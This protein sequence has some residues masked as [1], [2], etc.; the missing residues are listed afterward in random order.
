MTGFREQRTRPNYPD[1]LDMKCTIGKTGYSS[2]SGRPQFAFPSKVTFSG[3][4]EQRK[5]VKFNN[6]CYF[7]LVLYKAFFKKHLKLLLASILDAVDCGYHL[8]ASNVF[9]VKDKNIATVF[10]KG[11]SKRFHGLDESFYLCL[12]LSLYTFH[13]LMMINIWTLTLVCLNGIL[14]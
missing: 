11:I 7:F 5:L 8:L 9:G 4:R 3:C 6:I 2:I 1:V 14:Y 10:F 12:E 13:L